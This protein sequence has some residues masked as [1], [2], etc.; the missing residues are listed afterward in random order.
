[1]KKP[2]KLLSAADVKKST[3][4]WNLM[5]ICNEYDEIA[6]RIDEASKDCQYSINI[7]KINETNRKT[8]IDLG[9]QVIERPH[10]NG[11]MSIIISWK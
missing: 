7:L 9:Y 10:P 3:D 4:T 1:M 6:R 8:L 2:V 5:R 11:N